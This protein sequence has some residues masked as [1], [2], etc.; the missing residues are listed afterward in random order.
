MFFFF[1]KKIILAFM[2]HLNTWGLQRVVLS[3]RFPQVND[4]I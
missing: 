4:D 3:K 1:F 2:S